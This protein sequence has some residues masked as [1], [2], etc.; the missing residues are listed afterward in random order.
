MNTYYYEGP[1]MMFGKCVQPVYIASTCA[2]SEKKARS[3]LT[4]RWKK[5]HGKVAN[6]KVELTGK[7]VKV[8]LYTEEREGGMVYGEI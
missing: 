6:S 4:Y 2:P 5:D 8:G 3:N 1:V 7:I